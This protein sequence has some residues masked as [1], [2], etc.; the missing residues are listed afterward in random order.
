MKKAL[1]TN[2]YLAKYTGSEMHTVEMAKLLLQKGYDVTIAVQLK[3]YPLM[4]VIDE[5]GE[6]VRVIEC[7]KEE[8]VDTAYDLIIVQHYPVFDYLCCKYELTCENLAVSKLSVIS[9]Y[10]LLPACT[11]DADLILCVSDECAAGVEE[12]GV[13][14]SQIEVFKNSVSSSFFDCYKRGQKKTLKKIAVISNHIPY[15]ILECKEWMQG[16]CQVDLIGAQHTPRYVDEKLLTSYDLVITIGRTVQQC[17]AAGVPVYVYDYF[18]GPGYITDAN[19]ELAEKNNF[20]GRGFEHMDALAL[21][22]DI[23]ENYSSNLQRLDALHQVAAEKY[24]Y[25]K[26]FDHIHSRLMGMSRTRTCVYYSEVEKKCIAAYSRTMLDN[27]IEQS[28]ASQLYFDDGTGFS[29]ENSVRWQM[30]ENYELKK[31]FS[32]EKPVKALRFDPADCP[33]EFEILS[34]VVNGKEYSGK[35]GKKRRCLNF[36]PQYVIQLKETVAG[37]TNI[38]VTYRVNR[39]GVQE[40]YALLDQQLTD[41]NHG[42][43]AKL[44]GIKNR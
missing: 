6:H 32:V 12:Q 37:M 24:S 34:F 36:D 35:A 31:E 30:M 25:E 19:F 39:I 5:L 21:R 18:G 15:E 43:L 33:C 17:F 28:F 42:V 16:E 20:S 3:A 38:S 23:L 2:L 40:A 1:M 9:D 41:K 44:K 13:P 4:Q 10:E 29:E 7:Q 27:L 8:L 11:A 26:N 14:K 22:K